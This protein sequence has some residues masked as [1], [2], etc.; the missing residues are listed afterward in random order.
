MLPLSFVCFLPDVGIILGCAIS[1]FEVCIRFSGFVRCL[2][3]TRWDY[4]Q[5]VRFKELG[6]IPLAWVWSGVFSVLGGV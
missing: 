2:F 4:V 3:V 6:V 5:G 1:M